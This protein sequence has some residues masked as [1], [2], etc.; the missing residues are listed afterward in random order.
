MS[1]GRPANEFNR[2]CEAPSAIAA[3]KWQGHDANDHRG[4]CS[5]CGCNHHAAVAIFLDRA[6]DR[7][8]AAV[9]RTPPNGGGSFSLSGFLEGDFLLNSRWGP[10]GRREV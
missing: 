8:Q 10:E 9:G 5:D 7:C 4:C 1:K 6:I 2:C 3:K